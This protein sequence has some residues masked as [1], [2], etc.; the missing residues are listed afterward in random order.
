MSTIEEIIE[1]SLKELLKIGE[2]NTIRQ[3]AESNINQP[4]EFCPILPS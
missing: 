2:E 4:I 3:D 1:N